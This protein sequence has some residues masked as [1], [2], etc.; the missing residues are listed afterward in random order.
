MNGGDMTNDESKA[1]GLRAMAAGMEWTRGCLDGSTGMTVL[2]AW[3][4]G[5]STAAMAAFGLHQ[6]HTISLWQQS[7]LGWP[8][9]RD[10]ATL[11][12]LLAQVREAWE[13]HRGSDCIA[14]T[15]HTGTG[16]GV[17]ARYGSE[18]LATIVECTHETE[19]EA[20][21]AALESAN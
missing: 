15:M 6:S 9:L 18:G 7:N 5:G 16:W 19:A 8:D 17:R 1:L 13:P 14:S 11:G 12:V 20:L 2:A 3:H 21:V 4:I 10:P